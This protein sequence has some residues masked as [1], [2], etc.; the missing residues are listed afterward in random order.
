MRKLFFWS[1]AWLCLGVAMLGFIYSFREVLIAPYLKIMIISAVRQQLGLNLTIGRIA[2][3]YLTGVEIER[4]RTLR[5]NPAG[6]LVS[7]SLDRLKLHYALPA[8]FLSQTRFIQAL[9]VELQ[10]ARV[11]IM[12]KAQSDDKRPAQLFFKKQSPG[13]ILP[14]LPRLLIQD[15]QVSVQAPFL[16]IPELRVESRPETG[17]GN[18]IRVA[19]ERIE[20]KVSGLRPRTLSLETALAYSPTEISFKQLRLDQK[21]ALGSAR[22]KVHAQQITDFN[23]DLRLPPGTLTAAGR[24]GKKH[25][26][27]QFTFNSPRLQMLGEWVAWPPDFLSGAMQVRGELNVLPQDLTSGTGALAV[28]WHHGVLAGRRVERLDFS[29]A[30]RNG[31]LFL[32]QFGLVSGSN[33]VFL[34]SVAMPLAPLLAGHWGALLAAAR[35]EFSSQLKDLPGLLAALGQKKINLPQHTLLLAG[36][37]GQG[38]LRIA[39]GFLEMP[40]G[41]IRLN[42]FSA[43]LEALTG[44]WLETPFDADVTLQAGD[45][46]PWAQ[47]LDVSGINGAWEIEVNGQGRLG[48]FKAVVRAACSKLSYRPPGTEEVFI[49]AGKLDFQGAMEGSVQ[50]PKFTGQV[51]LEDGQVKLSN[52]FPVLQDIRLSAELNLGQAHVRTLEGKIGGSPWSLTGTV[53]EAFTA[54]PKFKLHLQGANLLFYRGQDMRVRADADVMVT[55]PLSKMLVTGEGRITDGLYSRDIDFLGFLKGNGRP[56]AQTGLVLFSLTDPPLN[57]LQ[58]GV[59][60]SSAN[61]FLIKNNAASGSVR[62]ELFLRGTGEEPV[63]TGTVY[64]DST[65]VALPTGIVTIQSGVVSFLENFPDIPRVDILAQAK[66]QGYD[67]T[68]RAAGPYDQAVVT[69]SSVPPASNDQLLLLVLTG[70]SPLFASG[71]RFVSAGNLAFYFGQGVAGRLFGETG[72]GILDRLQLNIGQ[73]ISRGG[74]E[75]LAAQYRL[76]QNWLTDRDILYLTSERDIYDDYNAG[77]KIVFQFK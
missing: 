36:T 47:L 17:G 21:S 77:A 45:I 46:G 22:F 53:E 52:D 38:Q 32:D 49:R 74:N 11:E 58:F 16:S 4:V 8:L 20:M 9:T 34:K 50:A 65:L 44:P 61:P 29:A 10:G 18:F 3:N 73:D 12:L 43:G 31:T 1:L 68:L 6:P 66:M 54:E 57:T 19:S 5:P 56:Q 24:W 76:T 40:Q 75:T 42:R 28:H 55:G 37:V 13:F 70:Q 69:L 27:A 14:V 23:L 72:R 60:I 39:R 62:P 59:R 64:I 67:I 35:G 33:Q 2:G 25:L 63:L 51:T 15:T 48:K 71:Q 26:S 30:L 41:K 7:L